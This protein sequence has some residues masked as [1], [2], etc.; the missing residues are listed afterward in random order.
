MNRI[1]SI[2]DIRDNNPCYDPSKYLAEDWSG[3]LTDILLTTAPVKDRIWVVSRF[4]DAKVNR[5]FAVYCARS[6]LSQVA[7]PDPRSLAACNVAEQCA[8]GY[9]TEE[10][11]TKARDDAYAAYAT[12]YANDATAYAYATASAYDA[13]A[14]DAAAAAA[15]YATYAAVYDAGVKFIDYYVKLLTNKEREE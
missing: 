10:Q 13:D 14:N 9:A 5:L 6:A 2:K 3:S 15:V 8:L 1:I 11:L 12:A 7:A 4:A